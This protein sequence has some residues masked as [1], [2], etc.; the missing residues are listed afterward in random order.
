MIKLAKN[1]LSFLDKKQKLQTMFLISLMLIAAITELIGLSL[2]LLLLNIFLGINN[3]LETGF[4]LSYFSSI[5]SDANFNKILIVF[6][7]IF[8]I[9][10]FIQIFVTWN[11][12]SFIAKFR[13]K[14]SLILYNN[15][16]R[17]DK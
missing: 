17:R 16:L 3:T 12:S 8:S 1:I 15:F 4:L 11:T 13:E 10:F 7:V 14:T 5:S 9:K 2:I 6:F